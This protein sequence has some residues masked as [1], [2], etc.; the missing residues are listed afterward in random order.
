MHSQSESKHMRELL[1]ASLGGKQYGIWKDAI[2]SVRDI[3]ALHRIP[4]SPCRIAGIMID[5]EK[6][7]TLGDLY[8]CIGY[9][10][11]TAIDQGDI[12]LMA[13]GGRVIGFSLQAVS[14]APS[15][16]SPSFFFRSRTISR[17]RYPTFGHFNSRHQ[18]TGGSCNYPGIAGENRIADPD[19]IFPGQRIR[20]I[21]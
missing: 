11:S 19:L 14:C 12:L 13:G 16:F 4:L 20:L 9:E 5:D 15:P 18:F 1:R 2:L 7:V 3:H 6:T 8:A 17:R 10:A 21:K